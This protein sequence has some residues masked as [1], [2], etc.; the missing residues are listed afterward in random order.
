MSI[1]IKDGF[2]LNRS[3]PI[4]DRIVASNLT[5][6]DNI[7]YKYNGLRTFVL[8]DQTPYVFINNTWKKELENS[9]VGTS[10]KNNYLVKFNDV[11]K[12]LTN[13]SIIDTGSCVFI[14]PTTPLNVVET[15]IKLNV[16]GVVKALTF[17]GIGTNLTNLNA[18]EIKSGLMDVKY[19][20]PSNYNQIFISENKS[21]KWED[22][23]NLSISL[24]SINQI[25]N[26]GKYEIV[27]NKENEV[28]KNS[29]I[30]GIYYN[31]GVNQILGKNLTKKPTYSF[32]DDDLSGFYLNDGL[33]FKVLDDD[34]LK[35]QTGSILL[36]NGDNINPSISFKSGENYGLY[37]NITDEYIGFSTN[38]SDAIKIFSDKLKV[39]RKLLFI[40]DQNTG[41]VNEND[42]IS[43]K[44]RN[45]NI[46][47]NSEEISFTTTN[48]F[49]SSSSTVGTL[50]TNGFIAST[51]TTKN[52]Y[53]TFKNGDKY[54]GLN[55]SYGSESMFIY[56]NYNPNDFN[57]I[58]SLRI[59]GSIFEI[60]GS[61]RLKLNFESTQLEISN[62]TY[63]D[64]I[65]SSNNNNKID[66]EFNN[67]S[68]SDKIETKG[69]GLSGYKNEI[70]I[71]NIQISTSTNIKKISGNSLFEL[72]TDISPSISTISLADIGLNEFTTE[73]KLKNEGGYIYKDL[74]IKIAL[75]SKISN[76]KVFIQNTF[77]LIIEYYTPKTGGTG[78]Y[79]YLKNNDYLIN[80]LVVSSVK[81]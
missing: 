41:I 76:L 44:N 23:K 8:S 71:E 6:R 24:F 1:E 14:N 67:L 12:G 56:P 2:K 36:L 54:S 51:D 52:T 3:V 10:L 33:C 22:S 26:N 30:N 9:L 64:F 28:Y 61:S 49:I 29:N 21:L 18:S 57:N 65:S 80:M 60:D 17:F 5:N 73:F 11:N 72:D 13:S 48:T 74:Y 81:A 59:S 50:K 39:N 77:D 43:L 53:L 63:L 40:G 69:I 27:L 20:K 62:N 37:S 75:R 45:S 46:T 78:I 4:D 7:A 70:Y 19:I 58:G 16:N 35:I 15:S 25:S 47:I 38:G 79:I 42:S 34:I 31:S 68:I 66:V 32:I 55:I